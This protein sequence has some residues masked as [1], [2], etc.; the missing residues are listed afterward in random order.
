[1]IFFYEFFFIHLNY[2]FKKNAHTLFVS[3]LEE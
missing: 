2:K 3:K 1:M